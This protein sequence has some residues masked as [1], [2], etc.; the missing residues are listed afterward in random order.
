M[1]LRDASNVQKTP[2]GKSM[3]DFVGAQ[4]FDSLQ[5]LGKDLPASVVSVDGSIVTVKL[6]IDNAPFT[7]PQITVP[8]IGPEYLRFPIQPGCKGRVTSTDARIGAMT[9]LG[10]GT[11]SLAPPG[12]LSALVFEPLGNA[13]WTPPTDPNKLEGY[14]PAGVILRDSAS[15]CTVVITTT[16]V[17]ITAADTATMQVGGNS[18]TVDSGGIHITGTLDINGAPYLAHIHSGVTTGSGDTGG[19]VP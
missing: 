6:E 11:A 3:H 12:N 18:I 4:S 19:V 8:L 15:N 10:L 5:L 17:T 16:M 13:D 9:G 1:N 14:G 7:L 2:F